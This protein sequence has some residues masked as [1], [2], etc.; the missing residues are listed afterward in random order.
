MTRPIT[1]REIQHFARLAI[2]CFY[3][4]SLLAL[5][6]CIVV[7][8]SSTSKTSVMHE[9]I[10]VTR[11][12]EYPFNDH[13]RKEKHFSFWMSARGDGEKNW[14]QLIEIPG[15]C[16]NLIKKSYNLSMA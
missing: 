5:H 2:P 15:V 4:Y 13:L 1:S 10:K 3:V 6:T 8:P 7:S 9:H 14:T 12:N 16:Q 11:I